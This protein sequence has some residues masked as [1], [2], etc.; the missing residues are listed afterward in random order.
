MCSPCRLSR[1]AFVARLALSS[2]R[3]EE[4]CGSTRT[5]NSLEAGCFMMTALVLRAVSLQ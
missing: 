1:G 3:R 5:R 2:M 4:T